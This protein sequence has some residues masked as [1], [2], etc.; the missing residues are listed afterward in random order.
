MNSYS[1]I[2]ETMSCCEATA[3]G[4]MCPQ[5]VKRGGKVCLFPT[6][7]KKARAEGKECHATTMKSKKSG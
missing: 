5:V 1:P 6:G 4:K 3:T 2:G 7:L